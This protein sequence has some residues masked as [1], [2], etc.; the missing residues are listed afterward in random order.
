MTHGRS[1]V[2]GAGLRILIVGAGIGGLALARI[3]VGEIGG[4]DGI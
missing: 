2:S 3:L 4:A 1:D